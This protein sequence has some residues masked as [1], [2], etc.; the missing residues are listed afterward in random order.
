[1]INETEN[2]NQIVDQLF[3]HESGKMV[4][5]L[6]KILGPSNIELAEDVVQD[7]II[8]AIN[9]WSYKGVPGN[10]TGWLYN[11]AK[12]K[13]INFLNR[14]KLRKKYSSELAHLL[15]SEWTARPA[16]NHF[17][18]EQEIEDDQLRMMFTCCHP[19]I[20]PD[21]QIA[22]TLKTL[23]GFS[24]PEIAKAFLTNEE[25]INKRLVRARKKIR[26]DEIPFE[27]PKGSELEKRLQTVLESIFLLFNE[28]YSA[29]KGNDII[30]Y[31]LCEEAIRLAYI[32]TGSETIQQKGNVF[33]LLSLMYL[34]ASRFKARQDG[35]GNLLTM[36]EQDR[37]LWDKRMIDIGINYLNQATKNGE[38]G[39][40]HSLAAI[41]SHH[42]IAVDFNATNWNAILALYDHLTLLDN[43]PL[44][45]LNRSVAVLK[46]HG[47]ENAIIELEKIETLPSLQSYHL[48]F[49]TKAEFYF[50]LNQYSKAAQ[51]L[52]K[53]ILLSSQ[54]A[55][56]ALLK[57]KLKLCT[58][59][60]I[61]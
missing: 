42:C 3:R 23:C 51:Y 52:E 13:A 9:Q 54:K 4:S 55:E 59:K 14:E 21:S 61:L 12:H 32:I 11:V 22:L 57:K 29:S 49:S 2:V 43:S 18:S 16:I 60:I 36:E 50:Q 48:L 38:V 53:A 37:S 40:Y 24:I 8:E 39:I 20:S 26:E 44:I 47:V 7:A 41:S 28:G 5:V 10:P 56:I 15:Q 58:Q 1:M 6:T 17:F 46:V 30:R 35:E 45:L 27:I 19:S 25:T 31:E 33:A 34:N